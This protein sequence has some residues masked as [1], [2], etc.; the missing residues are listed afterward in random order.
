MSSG[1]NQMVPNIH[2]NPLQTIIQMLFHSKIMTIPLMNH[3]LMPLGISRQPLQTSPK[4]DRLANR[5]LR[6]LLPMQDQGS[7]LQLRQISHWIR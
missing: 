7:R 1:L 3:L 5:N 6:I 2:K 4:Y